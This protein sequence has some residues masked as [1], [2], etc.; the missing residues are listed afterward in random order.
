MI[1][2]LLHFRNTDRVLWGRN[3]L[4]HGPNIAKKL[5]L[6]F[7]NLLNNLCSCADQLEFLNSVASFTPAEGYTVVTDLYWHIRGVGRQF[8]AI[9][10]G[11]AL[12]VEVATTLR[13]GV[14]RI[15]LMGVLNLVQ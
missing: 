13:R 4:L 9:F 15:P 6:C 5:C 3:K 14:A 12:L 11:R 10:P 2:Y 8:D 7:Q 1:H